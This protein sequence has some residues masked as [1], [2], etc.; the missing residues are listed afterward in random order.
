M[1]STAIGEEPSPARSESSSGSES[2]EERGYATRIFRPDGY[3]YYDAYKILPK[4]ACLIRKT[5]VKQGIPNLPDDVCELIGEYN[6]TNDEH[7]INRLEIARQAS[8]FILATLQKRMD[9]LKNRHPECVH[10]SDHYMNV[11][12]YF[13]ALKGD[14]FVNGL[15]KADDKYLLKIILPW[16]GLTDWGSSTGSKG[17]E[18]GGRTLQMENF[19]NK[20]HKFLKQMRHSAR[21]RANLKRL[22]REPPSSAEESVPASTALPES[23][24]PLSPHKLRALRAKHFGFKLSKE[25]KPNTGGKR[26]HTRKLRRKRKHSKRSCK[27]R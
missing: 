24:R 3:W 18:Y 27:R 12:N 16:L 10:S 14:E 6:W 11:I 25:D 20:L 1:D 23:V 5:V 22:A 4:F 7:G 19:K 17:G 13:R 8:Q 2:E 15:M 26:L 21:A 9:E